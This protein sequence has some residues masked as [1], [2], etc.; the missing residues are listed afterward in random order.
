MAIAPNTRVLVAGYGLPA[1]FCV[2]TLI[3]MGVEIDKIAV[4]THREDNR[5]CGLHSMLRLRNIQFTTAA[6]N[7]E[8]FYEFGANF[9]PDMIISMHYRSLIPGRFLKLAKKGSVN[10][11][12]SLLPAYRGTNSVAWVIINGESETGF[13]YHRMDENFDTGAILLQERIS[14]EETDTAFSLF[15]RQIARAMLR[16]EE[17]ILKLDQGDPG[18]AQLGEAS[19][20]ARE[21]PFGGVIDPRWS[22]V[23]IDR[24]IRAMFFPPFP[25]AVLKI[26]GK[27]YYVPSIDI[28]RSLMRGIP[29]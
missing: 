8:E 29:S 22:E 7:S 5:N 27:V 21:L 1:E 12:P 13:S 16:L 4:A 10:L 14:V 17:V 28:Y 9:D 11:H 24:F 19:Y 18:F 2:T 26:D 15:H 20:Y 6:A 25:P 3:G 23:Q